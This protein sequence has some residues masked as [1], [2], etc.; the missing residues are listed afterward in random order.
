MDGHM[1]IVGALVSWSWT[2]A[3]SAPAC[4]RTDLISTDA[5]YHQLTATQLLA[6]CF[7][8]GAIG[9]SQTWAATPLRVTTM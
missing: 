4:T 2:P 9:E 3:G 6:W 7:Q 1:N 8:P 5:L